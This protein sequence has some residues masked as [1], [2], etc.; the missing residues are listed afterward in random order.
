MRPQPSSFHTRGFPIAVAEMVGIVAQSQQ[1][2]IWMP[3]VHQ[4]PEWEVIASRV[5]PMGQHWVVEKEVFASVNPELDGLLRPDSKTGQTEGGSPATSRR[6]ASNRGESPS[7]ESDSEGNVFFNRRTAD[8]RRSHRRVPK[9][10]SNKVHLVF[11]SRGALSPQ[12]SAAHDKT[13]THP[14]ED[15]PISKTQNHGGRGGGPPGLRGRGGG[16]RPPGP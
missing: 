10:G 11:V 16:Q 4:K 6:N 13:K 1:V 8:R 15:F 5:H 2:S 12:L 14:P 7:I 9:S 3:K